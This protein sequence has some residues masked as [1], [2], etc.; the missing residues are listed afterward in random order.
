MTGFAVSLDIRKTRWHAFAARAS[1]SY[2]IQVFDRREST[3]PSEVPLTVAYL[4]TA[5]L[6]GFCYDIA[7]RQ[8]FCAN[9][10]VVW[11]V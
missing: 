7:K 4:L 1:F 5:M 9:T 8:P 2:Y 3:A 6:A 11:L 10:F